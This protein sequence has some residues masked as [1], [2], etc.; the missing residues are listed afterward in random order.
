LNQATSISVVSPGI[1][2]ND[3]DSDEDVLSAALVQGPAHAAS[4]QLSPDGSFSYSPQPYFYGEDTFTYV[5]RDG[6]NASQLATVH[7][8]VS[9]PGS[10][11]F[12][13]GGG[14]LMRN[15]GKCTFGFVAKL[16]PGGVDGELDFQDHD[17]DLNV[18]SVA[19]DVVFAA[20]ETEGYFG[21]TCTLNGECGYTF[22]AQVYDG[23]EP[24]S[25]DSLAIWVSDSFG[26]PV[27][28][29]GA[30]L[31]G[32]NITIHDNPADDGG[33]VDTDGDGLTDDLEPLYGTDPNDADTDDDLLSDGDE[34]L[35]WGT[36]PL[37]PDTDG[38]GASDGE[39]VLG[40][41]PYSCPDGTSFQ[42]DPLNWDTDG[43][44][45]GDGSGSGD[46]GQ[47]CC[48]LDDFAT[49]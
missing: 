32:G 46:S 26:T 37:N 16:Q 39:E 8:T 15:G 41:Y 13:T 42:T 20:D 43:D 18:R 12:I 47:D 19:P 17:A 23:G 45:Y 10:Q 25:N 14:K 28:T 3:S 38:D 30:V 35:T 40:L 24:G 33:P 22:F 9:Q 11:G 29:A 21:G 36:D 31:A 6:V 2:A 27:Y 5:S 4:F 48:P 7:I 34:V 49:C 44:N 1:L